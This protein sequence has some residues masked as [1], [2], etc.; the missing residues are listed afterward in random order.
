M[1][2]SSGWQ[3]THTELVGTLPFDVDDE[4][5]RHVKTIVV[6]NKADADGAG[7]RL[8]VLRELYESRF[9]ILC[10]SAAGSAGTGNA[11][12]RRIPSTGSASRLHES[13]WQT[14]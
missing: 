11:P 10:V 8:E 12:P 5:I 4:A 9:P 1:P 2:F 14:G 6:A 3:A 13:P 7:E